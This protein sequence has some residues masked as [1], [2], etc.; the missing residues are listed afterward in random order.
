MGASI[1]EIS[2]VLTSGPPAYPD[3]AA[4]LLSGLHGHPPHT[5]SEGRVSLAWSGT[6]EIAVR[7]ELVVVL[8]GRLDNR[9]ELESRLAASSGTPSAE[10]IA[11]AWRQ[12]GSDSLDWLVGDIAAIVFERTTGRIFG[13]RDLCAGRP[14][15]V[16]WDRDGWSVASDWRQIITHRIKTRQPEPEWFAGVLMGQQLDACATPYTG[17]KMVLPG[18]AASPEHSGWRQ[19]RHAEW[20]VPRL[21]DRRQG[22]Y[23][24]QFRALFDEAVSCR[25]TGADRVGVA[26]SGGLD[27]T[28]VIG[29]LAAVAPNV[30]RTALCVPLQEPEGDERDLQSLVAS[31]SGSSL[32]WVQTDNMYPFGTDGPI[33]LLERLGAPPYVINWFFGDALANEARVSGLPVVLDGEDGDGVVGGTMMFLADLLATG[34]WVRWYQEVNAIRARKQFSGRDCLWDSLNFASPPVI[35]RARLSRHGVSRTPAI[36]AERLQVDLDLEDRLHGTFLNNAW[37]PGRTFS[38]VQ[39]AV[40]QLEHVGPVFTAASDPWRRYGICLTH[41]WS[42]RRLMSFCMGLPYEH[43]I[44]GAAGL[45]KLV[46]RQAMADRL[47]EPIL[48]RRTKADIS[49]VTRRAVRGPQRGYL[50]EGLAIARTQ[51][52]WFDKSAVDEFE[53]EFESG[54]GEANATRTAM[55]AW[56]LRWCEAA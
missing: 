43:V 2:A 8:D 40:G 51:P 20:H 7:E 6:A 24:E 50:T 25:V 16:G 30:A 32:R 52:E 21:R 45:S 10:L 15:H 23:A 18:H 35:R 53:Q 47:P 5:W 26:L 44:D 14:L 28:S 3:V 22:A 4:E 46:L 54:E 55:L 36:I 29:T 49:E 9:R 19:S 17:A 37:R 27:S 1:G 38:L 56:W 11:Q 12:A 41:P 42:D 48:A 34:R 13:I 39:S 33:G 31:R